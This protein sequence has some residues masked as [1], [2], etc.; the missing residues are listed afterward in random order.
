M[1][2]TGL[3]LAA[4]GSRRLG[5]AKQLLPFRGAPLLQA[6]VGLARSA[7]FDQLIVTV[8]G[9]GLEV[10]AAVDLH[11]IAVVDNPDFGSGCASS[12]SRAV[13][14]VDPRA[15]GI[16]LMLGDQ[17]GVRLSTIRSLV[18]AAASTPLGVCRYDNG[19]GHPTRGHP[20]WLGQ[21]VFGRLLELHGD[22]AV[23]KVLESGEFAVT[24][25]DVAGPIPLDVDT[26]DDYQALLDLDRAGETR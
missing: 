10:K 11:G 16:V 8:G 26:W 14:V 12:I 22:K 25:V 7:D 3:V 1:F 18:D 21:E 17:P 13:A 2:V 19:S 15:D 24:E 23:W 5:Q 6:C 4:G 20:L 9:R